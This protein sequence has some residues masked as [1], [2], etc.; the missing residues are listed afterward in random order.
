MKV[1]SNFKPALVRLI[2]GWRAS[3]PQGRPFSGFGYLS[4]AKTVTLMSVTVSGTPAGTLQA[5][6]GAPFQCRKG[7]LMGYLCP[8]GTLGH[9]L[10]ILKCRFF[11]WMTVFCAWMTGRSF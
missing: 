8:Q 2:Y 1:A 5:P 6:T 9:F 7:F 11:E 4:R 10:S 3:S